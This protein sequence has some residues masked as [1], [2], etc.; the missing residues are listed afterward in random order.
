MTIVIRPS[1]SKVKA[2]AKNLKKENKI[3]HT[4]ALDLAA[5]EIGYPTF[6]ALNSYLKNLNKRHSGFPNAK[7]AGLNNVNQH[8]SLLVVFDDDLEVWCHE[9]SESEPTFTKKNFQTA[10]LDTG[11]A[12]QI[13][14]RVVSSKEVEQ[15]Q[16]QAPAGELGKDFLHDMGYVCIEF[17]RNKDNPWTIEDANKLVMDKVGGAI[18]ANYRDF[19]YLDGKLVDNHISDEWHAAWDS[20]VD[21]DYHPAID[22]Y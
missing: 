14:A 10:Y 13:G 4:K 18:G 3:K 6:Y 19:F 8:S 21:I 20:Y 15:R 5:Q 7:E 17:L 1:L 22:G 11:F 2:R 12:E 16:L 9:D